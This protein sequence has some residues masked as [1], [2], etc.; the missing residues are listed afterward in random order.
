ME[1]DLI[2]L[3]ILASFP[4]LIIPHSISL[5]VA[6]Y[7]VGVI[8][9]KPSLSSDLYAVLK[10][11]PSNA[12]KPPATFIKNTILFWSAAASWMTWTFRRHI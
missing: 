8:R 6:W 10:L 9:A 4:I 11:I 7:T 3:E 1:E 12:V 5:V 2:Q